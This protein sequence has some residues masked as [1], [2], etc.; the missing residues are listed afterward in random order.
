MYEI[1]L[2]TGFKAHEILRGEGVPHTKWLRGQGG[3]DT[4]KAE[5][6]CVEVIGKGSSEALRG[7]RYESIYSTVHTIHI[8]SQRQYSAASCLSSYV[9]NVFC[10]L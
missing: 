6:H 5:K 3:R 9:S 8:T 10:L 2:D 4:R 1:I 7:R